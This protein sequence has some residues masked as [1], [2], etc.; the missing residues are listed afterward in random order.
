VELPT[1]LPFE[2]VVPPQLPPGLTCKQLKRILSVDATEQGG[3]FGCR[4]FIL[5]TFFMAEWEA[6]EATMSNVLSPR[7]TILM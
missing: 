5:H 7:A 3:D 1:L 2:I 4:P 6:C